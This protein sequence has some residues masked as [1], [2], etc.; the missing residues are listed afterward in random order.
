MR[1]KGRIVKRLILRPR[2]FVEKVV[3]TKLASQQPN[4]PSPPGRSS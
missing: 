2:N 3:E 1:R 4:K